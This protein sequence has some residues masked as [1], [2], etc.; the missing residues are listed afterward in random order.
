LS[1]ADAAATAEPARAPRARLPIA[2]PGAIALGWVVIA[3]AQATGNARLVHHDAIIEGDVPLWLGVLLFVFAWQVML[4]AMMLPTTLP[5]IRHYAGFVSRTRDRDSNGALV[6][7][8]GAYALVWGVFGALAFTGDVALHR[9]VDATPWL[10]AHEYVIAGGVLA[11]AGAVQLLPL[12]DRCLTECRQ[13]YAYLVH[14]RLR[15][16]TSPFQL[17]LGHAL[18]CLGCCWALMLVVFA[19]GVASLVWMAAL[20]AV[21]LYEK[22]G[23]HGNAIRTVVGGVLILWAVLVF[24]HPSWLPHAAA[25]FA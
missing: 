3:V 2:I 17:G 14:Q 12:T 6:Q 19:A 15:G 4:A 10:E 11:L 22:V 1:G 9:V 24:A 25:S 5:M 8:L 7:F 20:G 21:M 16:V 18:F 23:R 13:P